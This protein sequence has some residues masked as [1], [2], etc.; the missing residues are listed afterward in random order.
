MA[1]HPLRF[2]F[3]SFK[4]RHLVVL[5]LDGIITE[6]VFGFN[7]VQLGHI[8]TESVCGTSPVVTGQRDINQIQT[9]YNLDLA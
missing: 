2:D 8:D 9:E 4:L 3:H 6:R 1:F 5:H 7:W